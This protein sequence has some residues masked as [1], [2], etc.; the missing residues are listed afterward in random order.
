M[1]IDFG[2]ARFQGQG[3]ALSDHIGGPGVGAAVKEEWFATVGDLKS[4]D[5]ANDD[6][7][8]AAFVNRFA[9]TFH[10][11]EATAQDWHTA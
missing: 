8:I 1:T 7:M 9:H 10:V 2:A 3:D 4:E 11:N 5:S 6:L